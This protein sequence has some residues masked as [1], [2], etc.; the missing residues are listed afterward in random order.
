MERKR[1]RIE[2]ERAADREKQRI[3]AERAKSQKRSRSNGWRVKEEY[4]KKEALLS[5]KLRK[6]EDAKSE[7]LN[8]KQNYRAMIEE[9]AQKVTAKTRDSLQKEFKRASQLQP[10]EHGQRRKTIRMCRHS[11]LR[12]RRKSTSAGRSV[13]Q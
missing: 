3:A 10:Q 13:L 7:A 6:A 9:E 1:S 12:L 5:S 11:R 2:A 4:F 8:L